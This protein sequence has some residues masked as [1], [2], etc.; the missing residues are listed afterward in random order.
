MDWGDFKLTA[1]LKIKIQRWEAIPKLRVRTVRALKNIQKAFSLNK[2]MKRRR[3]FLARR[4]Q[5]G[6]TAANLKL[7]NR[8]KRRGFKGQIRSGRGGEI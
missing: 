8:T 6:G 5:I 7:Q 3:G 2:N 4:S 1:E